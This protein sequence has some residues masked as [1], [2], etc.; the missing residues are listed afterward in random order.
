MWHILDIFV[1]IILLFIPLVISH[2]KYRRSIQGNKNGS[3]KAQNSSL[4]HVAQFFADSPEFTEHSNVGRAEKNKA[5]AIDVGIGVFFALSYYILRFLHY[6]W[7]RFTFFHIWTLIMSFTLPFI[8]AYFCKGESAERSA[9][10]AK[11]VAIV[12]ACIL[13]LSPLTRPILAPLFTD[14]LE[15]VLPLNVCP[16][17]SLLFLPAI[18]TGNK[19]LKNFMLSIALFGGIANNLQGLVH[20]Y[21][22]FWQYLNAETYLMHSLLIIIPLFVLATNQVTLSAEST[23]KNLA[24]LYPI[25]ILNIFLNP[26]L[27]TNYFFTRPDKVVPEAVSSIAHQLPYFTLFGTQISYLYLFAL[28]FLVTVGSLLLFVLAELFVKHIPKRTFLSHYFEEHK[29]GSIA[30]YS[31]D[32]NLIQNS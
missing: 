21:G 22:S 17:A 29:E 9:R 13:L 12:M 3:Y 18:V 4:K 24:W 23:V 30:N 10:V 5:L 32:K 31:A 26:I 27:D 8:L 2:I 16:I 14:S 7:G 20:T 11:R 28:A 19:M 6:D 1:I 15:L 25:F